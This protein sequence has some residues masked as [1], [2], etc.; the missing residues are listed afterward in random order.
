MPLYEYHCDSCGNNFEKLQRFSD[1]PLSVHEECGGGPVHRLISTSALQFKGTGFYITDYKKSNSSNSSKD[2][3]S[4]GG[5]AS[6]GDSGGS[7]E[8]RKSGESKPAGESKSSS[9]SKPAAT[10]APSSDTKNK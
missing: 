9:D 3:K 10:P 8:S 1:E 5:K 6:A 7:G 4:D 2:S